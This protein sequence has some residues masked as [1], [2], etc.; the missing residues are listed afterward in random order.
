MSA[1]EYEYFK[2]KSRSRV[3]R[4]AVDFNG[5][6]GNRDLTKDIPLRN[7]DIVTIPRKRQVVSVSGEV[8]NPGFL[9]YVPGKDYNYYIATAGGYSDQAGRNNVS[10]IKTATG[11]WKKAKKGKGLEPG[12]TVWIP[13][14]KKHNYIVNIKDIAVF[15]GNLATIYLVIQQATQ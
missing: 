15:I 5:L 4:V 11:E 9:T 3:G 10:I 12:D 14:K 13:E 7:S 1:S 8:A 2:I 6:F